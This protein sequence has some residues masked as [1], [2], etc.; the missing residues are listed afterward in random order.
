LKNS[1]HIV[2]CNFNEEIEWLSKSPYPVHFVSKNGKEKKFENVDFPLSVDFVPNTALEVTSYLFYII[3]YYNELPD[4]IAFI[5]GHENSYHQKVP[6]FE[7]IEKNKL[8][9]FA[10]LNQYVHSRTI[11]LK[12][13]IY[14]HL[15]NYFFEEPVP[16]Y[17]DFKYG[18]QF[19]VSKEK[20][21][22]RT[23]DFYE[24]L[25]DKLINCNFLLMKK[26]FINT[27]KN[28]DHKN[29]YIQNQEIMNLF[30]YI[31]EQEE[32]FYSKIYGQFFEAVWHLIFNSQ[33]TLIDGYRKNFDTSP[34][35]NFEIQEVY[36]NLE[37]FEKKLK[38]LKN[39][40]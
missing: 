33:C 20:I 14:F 35:K 4:K 6:I 18:A 36:E 27:L 2:S 34:K 15:W 23:K 39:E 40:I 26:G 11:I 38:E 37:S 19:L 12:E 30:M 13:S 32:N 1:I 16:L 5:H 17:L 7:S 22:T 9:D 31:L 29:P 25:Y 21:K 24:N 10:D 3:K 28:P 8:S